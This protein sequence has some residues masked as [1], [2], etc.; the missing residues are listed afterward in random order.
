MKKYALL[1][2][3]VLMAL[4][5]ACTPTGGQESAAVEPT[6]SSQE[7]G[8]MK[9]LYVEP[10]LV[11]CVGVAPMQCM[12]VKED[13]NGEYLNFFNQIEG[14]TFEPGFTYELRVNVEPVANPPADGSAL[15]YTLVEVVSKTAVE[16]TAT[17]ANELQ[18]VR[19]VLVSYR[20]AAGETV[21]ALPDREV[22]AEFGADGRVAGSGGCNNYFASYTVDGSNLT[23]SQAGSTMMAC[24][25]VEVMQQEADFLAALGTA[26]TWQIDGETLT[27]FN[28]AGEP[29]VVFQAAAAQ[30]LPGTNWTVVNFNTGA[31]ITGPLEGTTLTMAFGE[32]GQVTGSAGCNNYF[33]SYTVDGQNLT[34]GQAGSTMMACEPAEIMQQETQFLTALGNAATWSINA[35]GQLQILDAEGLI[36]GIFDPIVPTSLTGTTWVATMV[37]NGR[38]AVTNLVA[39]TTITAVFTED[40]KLNGS[41]GCN[42]YMTGYTLDGANITI[43]PPAS[44]RKMCA[45]EGVMAQ[46]AAYLSLLPTASAWRIDGTTLELRT[47]DGALIASYTAQAAE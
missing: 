4:A 16:Q 33:A 9:T 24:E 42:N 18:G 30:S 17:E 22:T 5:A 7:Q 47:A 23:I 32:D 38:Q 15:R 20:N 37:N 27:I 39:G 36:V 41:A 31:A 45:E 43:E 12:Q 19:W 35:N 14:F 44:T 29:A 40:G 8:E 6:T 26:A 28:A 13:P 11:D 21:N 46:E 10:E 1:T 2:L 34:I 25:P 3:V